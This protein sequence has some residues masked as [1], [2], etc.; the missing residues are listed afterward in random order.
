MSIA[1]YKVSGYSTHEEKQSERHEKFVPNAKA[2]SP[3]TNANTAD[4]T[5]QPLPVTRDQKIFG[6]DICA[7]P[8]SYMS[9]NNK[10][11]TSM[12]LNEYQKAAM[13]RTE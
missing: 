8:E 2:S 11:N 4:I 7:M 6:R 5:I 13:G 9:I 10:N 12:T 1:R 3:C